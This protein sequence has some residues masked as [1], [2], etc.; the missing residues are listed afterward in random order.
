[1]NKIETWNSISALPAFKDTK[2]LA[3][4]LQKISPVFAAEFVNQI[5]TE[6]LRC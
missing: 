2:E 3:I 6:L 4:Q 1:M 5:Y